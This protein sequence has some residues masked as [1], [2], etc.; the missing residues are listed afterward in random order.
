MAVAIGVAG[1]GVLA[2]CGWGIATSSYTDD[3]GIDAAFT[4][5]RF[6]NDSGDMTIR[7]GDEASVHRTVHHGGDK[8]GGDTFR[9]RDGVLELDSCG[10]PQCWIDY[11]VTVPAGTT[12]SGQLDSGTT[13]VSGVAE[14]NVR[15]SSGEVTVEDVAGAVN[16]EAESGSV[17]LSDIGGA[18]VA[19]AESGNV[20]AD[21]VRGDVTLQASSGNVGVELAA[22]RDVRVKAESG[23]VEVAVPDGAYQVTADTDSGDV[24]SDVTDDAAGDH[25]LDLHTDSGNI[26]V[27]RA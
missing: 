6:A 20:H 21:D 2:G 19:K 15:A 12:V 9:V 13:T 11:E 16:I 27:T 4:S 3:K 25:H 1:V 26:T 18:V 23:N 10:E 5:V 7:A 17:N 24:E 14:V 22:A 8:P